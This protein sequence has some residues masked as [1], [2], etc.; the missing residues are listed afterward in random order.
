MCFFLTSITG[1][2]EYLLKHFLK[3]NKTGPT[4]KCQ[5][6]TYWIKVQGRVKILK[7]SHLLMSGS[8]YKSLEGILNLFEKM[9]K[10]GSAKLEKL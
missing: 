2:F 10:I 5:H 4:K 6:N 9:A 7:Y 8:F 3:S 1:K